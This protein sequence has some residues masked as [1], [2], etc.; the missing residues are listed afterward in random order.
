M[1][2]S[3]A[4]SATSPC[5]AVDVLKLAFYPYCIIL[6]FN[7]IFSM[8]YTDREPALSR[9]SPKIHVVFP[10]SRKEL[11]LVFDLNVNVIE[12]W[13]VSAAQW[14]LVSLVSLYV[15]IVTAVS[16]QTVVGEA[17]ARCC[18][19]ALSNP[20]AF[21]PFQLTFSLHYLSQPSAP[22]KF[23]EF[24]SD[25][26]RRRSDCCARPSTLFSSSKDSLLCV[27]LVT[28]CAECCVLVHNRRP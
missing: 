11:G 21:L 16:A 15:S 26:R 18:L 25:E 14:F 27:V 2:T 9:V 4:S 7:L 24:A 19:S 3:V 23:A 17:V 13:P 10:K 8:I 22:R 28:A 1:L 20:H 12:P 6:Y 5:S